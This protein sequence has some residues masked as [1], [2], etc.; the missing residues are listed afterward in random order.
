LNKNYLDTDALAKISAH[1]KSKECSCPLKSH[2][3]W[4]SIPEHRWPQEHLT[5]QGTLRKSNT[6]EPCFDEYHPSGTRFESA[7]APV[8]LDFFPYN[9]ST[10]FLCEHCHQT[11]LKYTE[12]GGYYVEQRARRIDASLIVTPTNAPVGFG[13]Q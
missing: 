4:Q 10:V 13:S 6:E 7:N 12:T 11:V 9:H 3:G 5:E 8:A 1:K 2:T